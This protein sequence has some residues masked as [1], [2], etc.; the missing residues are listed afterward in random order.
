[1]TQR[2]LEDS[3]V[4][5]L[6]RKQNYSAYLQLEA[7]LACQQELSDPPHH[8]EMLFIIQHQVAELWMKLLIHE[9]EAAIA[10][11]QDDR[12]GKAVKHLA[13]V[14]AIQKQLYNQWSVLETLTPSEYAEF[15][16][17]FGNASGFQSPQ[18]RMLEILLG[19]RNP[20]LLKVYAHRPRW[21]AMLSE[22]IEAPGVF[23]EFLAFLARA[24]HDIPDSVLNRDFSKTRPVDD[25]V[26]AVLT[27]IYENTEAHWQLYEMCESL[28]DI[29]SNFQ[30]WR[31]RHMKTVERI[32]GHQ[33]GSGGSS[34]VSFLRRAIEQE[35]FED[36]IAVRTK[37]HS[38]TLA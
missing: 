5:D 6:S 25:S 28:V 26:V 21:H 2:E 17:V 22:A 36:L 20:S 11:L 12:L 16:N 10:R 34:G 18:Y 35:F 31:F 24:G 27:K 9:F 33:H 4:T 13:R 32:I 1:M 29:A 14:K 8:D 30:F 37:M 7:L 19:N 23:D 15:R 3:I 38:N